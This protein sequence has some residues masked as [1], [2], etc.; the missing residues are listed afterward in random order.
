MNTMTNIKL[1]ENIYD[2]KLRSI[3]NFDKY[4]RE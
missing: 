3:T 1:A 4:K 2:L